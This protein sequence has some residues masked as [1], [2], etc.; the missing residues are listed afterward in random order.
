MELFCTYCTN[1]IRGGCDSKIARVKCGRC[2]A[3]GSY[4]S[5]STVMRK[6]NCATRYILMAN[7]T[8][9]NEQQK[10]L[11]TNEEMGYIGAFPF[12]RFPS[13]L[14][15][16]RIFND[17]KLCAQRPST[18]RRA[19]E[20]NKMYAS[21]DTELINS[22]LSYRRKYDNL[23]DITAQGGQPEKEISKESLLPL[24]HNF[25]VEKCRFKSFYNI[26]EIH[27]SVYQQC[28]LGGS[29]QEY[30]KDTSMCS[31]PTT[32]SHLS[33]PRTMNAGGDLEEVSKKRKKKIVIKMPR[34]DEIYAED[35]ELTIRPAN[36]VF[37]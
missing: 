16:W 14:N 13:R 32:E 28:K 8:L 6:K 12:R 36:A 10:Q 15:G 33:L 18:E 27:R 23:P 17:R 25:L 29:T 31:V 2:S 4:K 5:N 35:S 26:D 24:V 34:T 1:T 22:T 30:Y 19:A 7:G 3:M 37:C 9:K 11:E 20:S 21:S